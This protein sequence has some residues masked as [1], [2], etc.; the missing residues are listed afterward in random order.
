MTAMDYLSEPLH[1]TKNK[2]PEEKKKFPAV[3]ST[4]NFTIVRIG[5]NNVKEEVNRQIDINAAWRDHVK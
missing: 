1:W 5:R 3:G 4:N 2:R